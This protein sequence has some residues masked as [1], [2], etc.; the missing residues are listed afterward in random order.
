MKLDNFQNA[1]LGNWTMARYFIGGM[2]TII[3]SMKGVHFK[4]IFAG[5]F[6][7]MSAMFIYFEVDG[8]DYQTYKN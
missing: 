1:M 3:L 8:P 6:L 2:T 5:G 7:I 4:Y